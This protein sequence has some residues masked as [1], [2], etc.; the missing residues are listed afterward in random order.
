MSGIETFLTLLGVLL[1]A[2]ALHEATHY[3]AARLLGREAV[4]VFREWAVFYDGHTPPGRTE[5]LIAG[6]PVIVG[7][8]L[9]PA[10]VF[11]FGVNIVWLL[12]WFLYTVMG[13]V[14][15][16]FDFESADVHSDATRH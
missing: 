2:S 6:A 7:I 12:P 9:L 16:D 10:F 11:L 1:L 8:A 3:V 15:N 5:Y 4:F 14:T 13:A